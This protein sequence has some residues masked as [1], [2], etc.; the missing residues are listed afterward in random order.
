MI[1]NAMEPQRQVISMDGIF[2]LPAAQQVARALEAAPA[3]QEVRL[4]LSRVREFH[5]FSV[6]VLA[7]ALQG[8]RVDV[9]GLR[10]HQLRLLR[11]MGVEMVDPVPV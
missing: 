3:G 6:A 11:Y 2:D 4:D 5:D 1:V 7:R 8:R 10:V 9:R